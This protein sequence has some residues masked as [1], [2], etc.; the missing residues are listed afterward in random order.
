MT[1]P[2]ER[3]KQDLMD[4]GFDFSITD[5]HLRGYHL[6][7]TLQKDD[8]R[9]FTQKA[10]KYGFYLVFVSGM[11]VKPGE[12][13]KKVTSGL[14]AIYQFARY[15]MLCRI[16][17]IVAVPE[18]MNIPSINDIYQGANWHE[19]ETR[20]FFGIIF[21]GH[22]NLKPLLLSDEDQNFHPLLKEEK[23]LKNLEAVSWSS[24]TADDEGA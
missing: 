16:K 20:D 24:E 11:H 18:D 14:Y 15:D 1:N 3:F 17:C 22:P 9:K 6:E 12:T 21:D 19:R 2:Y 23:K 4:E 7:V 5:Y 10:Y 8:I 13:E